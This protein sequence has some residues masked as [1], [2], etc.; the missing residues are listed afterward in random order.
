M[1]VT[2]NQSYQGY[3]AGKTVEL[4]ASTEAA[5]I[6]QGIGTLAST[7][8]T[9][10]AQ[11][12]YQMAG[13]AVIA[14]AAASVVVTNPKIN[15]TCKIVPVIAQATGDAT[16]L[17]LRCVPASGSFTIYGNA[18]ATADTVIDWIAFNPEYLSS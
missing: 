12:T 16:L 10:G 18:A 8:S 6:A 11:T 5:V 9:S 13:Q 17:Y 4:P 14:A 3:A 15:A 1:T 7:V 2:L